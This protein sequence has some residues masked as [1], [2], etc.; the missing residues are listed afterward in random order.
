MFLRNILI[1]YYIMLSV[2]MM[3]SII[4][5]YLFVLVNVFWIKFICLITGSFSM[6][7]STNMLILIWYIVNENNF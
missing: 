4:L 1:Q 6:I 7:F 2:S 3:C 5:F